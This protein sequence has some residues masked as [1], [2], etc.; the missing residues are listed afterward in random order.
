VYFLQPIEGLLEKIT[1][2]VLHRAR[3]GEEDY[4]IYFD[5]MNNSDR[6][7]GTWNRRESDMSADEKVPREALQKA[8]QDR[9]PDCSILLCELPAPHNHSHPNELIKSIRIEWAK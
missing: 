5:K 8:L 6:I 2:E 1:E 9:F 3:Y 7:Y 4:C